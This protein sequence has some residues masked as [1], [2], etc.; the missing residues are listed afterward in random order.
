MTTTFLTVGF[1][2]VHQLSVKKPQTNTIIWVGTC[3]DVY[4]RMCGIHIFISEWALCLKVILPFISH[5][6][7]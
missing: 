3:M 1:T 4:V 5:Q 2:N 6:Q 7:L